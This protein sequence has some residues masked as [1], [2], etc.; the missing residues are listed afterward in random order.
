MFQAS[1]VYD[2]TTLHW[3]L[4]FFTLFFFYKKRKNKHI[5]SS[6]LH[7]FVMLCC[8]Y[9]LVL[10][11]FSFKGWFLVRR[12]KFK[13]DSKWIQSVFKVDSKWIQS[14]FRHVDGRQVNS[15]W[16]LW[17]SVGLDHWSMAPTVSRRF[18]FE[19]ILN[20]LWTHFDPILNPF[21]THIE[22]SSYTHWSAVSLPQNDWQSGG[23]IA[24]TSVFK[25][26]SKCRWWIYLST[27]NCEHIFEIGIS[28]CNEWIFLVSGCHEMEG[29]WMRVY[30]SWVL[31][32]MIPA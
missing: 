23:T 29:V 26:Y 11:V 32:L 18:H 10:W 24:N 4:A 13:M 6:L 25:V 9:G 21:W 3:R 8:L 5:H 14:L 16:L 22:Y 17:F 15:R 1:A 28:N 7:F 2:V 30:V 12:L 20:P 19:C 31:L 27:F